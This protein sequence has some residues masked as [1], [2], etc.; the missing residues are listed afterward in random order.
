MAEIQQIWTNVPLIHP[1]CLIV[2]GLLLIRQVD[3][4][5]HGPDDR[6]PYIYALGDSTVYVLLFFVLLVLL[7]LVLLVLLLLVPLL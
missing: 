3:I 6:K 7:L 5:Q 2:Q 4:C 1:I